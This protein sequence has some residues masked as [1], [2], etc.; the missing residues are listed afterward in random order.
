MKI[1]VAWISL[2]ISVTFPS[3]ASE[4]YTAMYGD[5][6][7]PAIIFFHGGPGFNS[8]TFEFTTAQ[9][10]A[11]KG[12]Y[13][14][15]YDQR[16]SGRSRDVSPAEYTFEECNADIN[17]IYKKYNLTKATLMGHSWGGAVAIK[18][19]FAHSDKVQ[20]IILIG[21]PLSY[22]QTLM[23]IANKCKK[24]YALKTSEQEYL[25]IFNQMD[26]TSLDYALYCLKH[27]VKLNVGFYSVKDPTE[28]AQMIWGK[29]IGKLIQQDDS[30]LSEENSDP[31]NGFYKNEHWTTLDLSPQLIEL[32]KK[33]NIYG[34]YGAEDGLFESRQLDQLKSIIGTENFFLFENSAHSVFCD[35]QDLFLKTVCNALQNEKRR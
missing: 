18:Y 28:S 22:Q 26:T 13:V 23:A 9:A 30:N 6:T 4:L 10:L 35:Q 19:A 32:H 11:D 14:I 5:S 25:E 34:M 33:M 21:S 15:I 8:T 31:I 29:Y 2:I 24:I 7:K 3:K 20:N 12:F 1:I 17:Y 16:G 27:A